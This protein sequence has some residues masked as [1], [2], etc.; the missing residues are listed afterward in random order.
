[1]RKC[2]IIFEIANV[3]YMIDCFYEVWYP[4]KLIYWIMLLKIAFIAFCSAIMQCLLAIMANFIRSEN[5]IRLAISFG[6]IFM[7]HSE[8]NRYSPCNFIWGEFNIC[9]IS[10]GMNSI[11]VKFHSAWIQYLWNFIW[12]GTHKPKFDNRKRDVWNIAI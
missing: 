4:P 10:F 1:M 9:E 12:R 2:H 6:V 8:W 7:F 11:F 3:Q 5:F